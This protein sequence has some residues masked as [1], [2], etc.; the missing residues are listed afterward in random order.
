M[1]FETLNEDSRI[2]TPIPTQR[3]AVARCSVILNRESGTISEIWNDKFRE[4]LLEALR[5]NGWDPQLHYVAGDAIEQTVRSAI[6]EEVDA[7]IAGGGDGTTTS[8]ASMLRASGI[9]LGI[10]P[11]GTL[12]LAARDLDTDLDPIEA[13]RS[14]KPGRIRKIDMLEVNGKP[15][16]C[17]TI[18]GVYPEL[19]KYSEEFHGR[20][21]L[22]KFWKLGRQ[23]AVSY[24]KAPKLRLRVGLDKKDERLISTRF[25]LIVPGEHQDR[26]GLV[27]RRGRLDTGRASVYISKHHSRLS[28]VRMVFRFLTAQ[29]SRDPDLLV[30]EAKRIVVEIS[31]RSSIL[32]AIDG[33]LTE[34]ELPIEFDLTP[35][36]LTVLDPQPPDAEV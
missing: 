12:N 16:L 13:V 27:P 1:I 25:L 29:S 31:S 5:S 8:I 3:E 4:D 17:M 14:L 23:M 28:V 6:E 32:A 19:M 21:W 36:E 10:L 26:W 33:E 22:L 30:E 20:N 24:F 35:C 7:I 18:L 15:C 34:L 11:F 2:P 9:P